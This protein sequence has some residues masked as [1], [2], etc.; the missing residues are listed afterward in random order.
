ML[1]GCIVL[2]GDLVSTIHCTQIAAT[3]V[4][5]ACF[6]QSE[7]M[8]LLSQRESL[9]QQTLFS[10]KTACENG[11]DLAAGSAAQQGSLLLC[12]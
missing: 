10:N 11:E 1:F 9:R 7:E 5:T 8:N 12:A 4:L 2:Q 6:H 3:E